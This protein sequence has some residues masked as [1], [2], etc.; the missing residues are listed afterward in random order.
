M[1]QI[2]I[3]NFAPSLK[4]KL[5]SFSAGGTSKLASSIAEFQRLITFIHLQ[6][7]YAER[8]WIRADGDESGRDA[9]R[10]IRDK[11]KYFDD[12]T[13]SCFTKNSFEYYYPSRFESRVKE[14][15]SIND[16]AIRRTEKARLLQDAIQWTADGGNETVKA[17]DSSAAEPI[18]LLRS[19]AATIG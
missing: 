19:I 14:V 4:G 3:P 1:N 12:Q 13:C 7:A 9:I 17:W 2:L 15:L 5:R 18:T 10:A 11:F 6:P 16:K 8:I